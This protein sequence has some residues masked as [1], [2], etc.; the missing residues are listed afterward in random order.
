MKQLFIFIGVLLIPISVQA[1]SLV[2]KITDRDKQPVTFANAILLDAD[3]TFITGSVSDDSGGFQLSLPNNATLLKVSYI[4]FQ[5]KVMLLKLGQTDLGSIELEQETQMLGEVLVRGNLPT[6]H[7]KGDAMVTNVAG[8]VLEKAGSAQDVLVKVPGIAQKGEVL[9]VFG[10][11]VPK[12]YINGREMRDPSELNQLTSDNIKS[13]EVITNPGARYDKTTKAVIRIQTKKKADDGFGFADRA[14]LSYN[15][16]IS[17]MNQLDLTYRRDKIDLVGMFS[18]SD[19]SS[20]RNFNAVQKTYL[21]NYWEQQMRSKQNLTSQQL[22]GNFALN[23]T[24]N[25]NHSLGASYQYK[26]YPTFSNDLSLQTSVYQDRSVFEK[27]ISNLNGESPETRHEGNIYYSGKLGEWGIDFNG[28]LLRKKE[29]VL[30]LTQEDITTMTGEKEQNIVH[31]HTDTRN[32]F[33]AGKLVLTYPLFSGDLSFGGEYTH[34]LRTSKYQ[35]KEGIVDNDDSKIKEGLM[36]AFA[37]YS[38]EFGKINLQAGLRFENVNFDYYKSD[39]FQKEQSRDYSNLFPSLSVFIPVGKVEAQ[40]SYTSDITR[41]TYEMLRNR[42]DYINR[43]TYESGNPFLR[44]SITHT[45]AINATYKWW[46]LYADLQHNKD[47][48]VFS[49]GMYSDADPNIALLRQVNAPSYNAMNVMLSAAPTIGCWSP[50]FGLE[51]YK[52]WYTVEAPGT[53]DGKLSLNKPSYAARWKNAIELPLGFTL[54]ADFNWEGK[55]EQDNMSYKAV[56]SAN[57]SLYKDFFNQRLTFL[58]QANDLFNTYHT[59]YTVYYGRLRT[60]SMNEKYSRRS[61]GLT[62]QYKFNILKNKYK[63]TGAGES[64]VGRL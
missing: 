43:Y 13:V 15:D 52:Q 2:G 1:Q 36:A 30:G 41:P 16:K 26:R 4:G 17:Y 51:L 3:S 50:Q 48:V 54:N 8:S 29:N 44:P 64:Q 12:I 7:I 33:Y 37:E 21:E 45:F 27:S 22:T 56:W 20:W 6:T 62:V 32:T 61:I 58:L 18:Y 31:T 57:A 47:A 35:N 39:I 42:I 49:S 19:Q 24:L 14:N 34:T 53:L 11:G 38:R 5:E 55:T 9:N 40:L 46:L 23:Y 59:N 28:T 10:R 63:G 60:M 25:P